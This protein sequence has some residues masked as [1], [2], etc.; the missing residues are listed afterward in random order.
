MPFFRRRKANLPLNKRVNVHFKFLRE[1][2]NREGKT[3]E[4][5]NFC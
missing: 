4:S 1:L 2:E 5:L 3:R